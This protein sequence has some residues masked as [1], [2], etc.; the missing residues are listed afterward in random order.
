MSKLI[1][2]AICLFSLLTVLTG[3]LYPLAVTG[4]ARWALPEQ[5]T[6]SLILADGQALGSALIGQPFSDPK[7]FWGR[8][9]ATSPFPYNAAASSGSNLGPL[10]PALLEAV[11]ARVEAIR[12]SDPSEARPVPVDLVTTSGSG[13]DPHISPAGAEYQV[14]RVAKARGLDEERV[15]KLVADHTEGRQF[16]ILGEPRVHVLRLNLALDA[17]PSMDPAIETRE[18]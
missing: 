9:S 10:N 18:R 17:P 1:K 16:G 3:I 6:G 2:P 8:P 11:K 5:A 12:Q 4:I 13:L 7:Y 15:R 14:S